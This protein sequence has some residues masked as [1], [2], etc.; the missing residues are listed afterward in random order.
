MSRSHYTYQR[1]EGEI[2]FFLCVC[3]CWVL[4]A[5]CVCVCLLTL[6]YL[7]FLILKSLFFP[8]SGTH[9]VWCLAPPF[10]DPHRI[11]N[12]KNDPLINVALHRA[13]VEKNVTSRKTKIVYYS[14]S[15]STPLI[16]FMSTLYIYCNP[17][18][19]QFVTPI[20]LLKFIQR[21]RWL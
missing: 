1:R 8:A 5:V 19:I 3:E 6:F 9:T 11:W 21:T 12:E 16:S 15:G 7:F 10:C 17:Y 2:V 20:Y 13:N 4:F 14:I 18:N